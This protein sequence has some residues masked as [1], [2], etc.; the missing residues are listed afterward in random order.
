MPEDIDDQTLT[1]STV[2]FPCLPHGNV[3][4][5]IRISTRYILT[6]NMT[7]LYYVLFDAYS[8]NLINKIIILHNLSDNIDYSVYHN[9]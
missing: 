5:K 4:T 8:W 3:A 2:G 1:T 7:S 9:F 6:L